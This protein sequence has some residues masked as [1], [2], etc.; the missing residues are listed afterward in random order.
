MLVEKEELLNKL[1]AYIEALKDKEEAE[2]EIERLKARI[3]V[4]VDPTYDYSFMRF[5]W[6]FLVFYPILAAIVWV[7][8]IAHQEVP[9]GYMPV[10]W[11]LITVIYFAASLVAARA[12]RKKACMKL[13]QERV[14]ITQVEDRKLAGR[15]AQ[16]EESLGATK[17]FLNDNKDIVPVR[18]R[19]IESLKEIKSKI[20]RGQASTIEEAIGQK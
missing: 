8:I 17:Q 4:D 14:E 12:W 20:A 6:P 2:E 16:V 1:S 11:I 10:L 19:N 13:Y 18:Y 3:G 9:A 5:F 7:V 15:L